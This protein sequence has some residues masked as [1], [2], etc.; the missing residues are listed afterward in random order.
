[1]AVKSQKRGT[2][3]AT[4]ATPQ[5]TGPDIPAWLAKRAHI[6]AIALVVLATVRIVATYT[7][8]NHTFD[9]P[10]HIA[11]GTEWLADGVYKWE[12]QHPP[13]SRVAVSLG[14]FFMGA[15]PPR[16]PRVDIYAMSRE[17]AAIL[18]SGH[19]Y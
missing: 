13:L 12:D 3:P 1:M 18:Y 17:G 4:P 5:P 14:P 9:E 11:C 6:L 10:A 2:P 8:F 15:R 19:R 16:T 7:V